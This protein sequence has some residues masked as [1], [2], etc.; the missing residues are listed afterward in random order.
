MTAT[1]RDEY[2]D[3]VPGMPRLQGPLEAHGGRMLPARTALALALVIAGA[4]LAIFG[5]A[6]YDVRAGIIVAGG[7][8][9]TLGVLVGFTA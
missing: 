2:V 5:A 9:L 1:Q 3:R 6:L 8:V 7:L 4:A